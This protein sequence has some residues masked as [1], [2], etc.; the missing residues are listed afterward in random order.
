MQA[1]HGR[2]HF[3]VLLTNLCR[4]C[5]RVVTDAGVLHLGPPD[6]VLT[7]KRW[8]APDNGLQVSL[9]E[10]GPDAVDAVLAA[11]AAAMQGDGEHAAHSPQWLQHLAIS[12]AAY[13]V[14]PDGRL[15][16]AALLAEPQGQ[17]LLQDRW[18]GASVAA[19]SDGML[20]VTWQPG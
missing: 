17:R 20:A 6:P 13:F 18:P 2:R 14:L 10:E 15:V 8:L 11:L 1:F 16:P 12:A 9:A 19:A 5:R 4:Q 3:K 7:T